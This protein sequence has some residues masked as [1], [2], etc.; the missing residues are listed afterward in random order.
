M[1]VRWSAASL[2]SG[3]QGLSQGIWRGRVLAMDVQMLPV[4]KLPTNLTHQS[5]QAKKINQVICKLIYLTKI[6]PKYSSF[7]IYNRLLSLRSLLPAEQRAVGPHDLQ[8]L[9]CN[10]Q[11]SV[12]SLP[13]ASKMACFTAPFRISLTPNILSC[14]LY[15]VPTL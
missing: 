8:C 10:P 14:L 15:G 3:E 5:N 9:S 7:T 12:R 1:N 4:I 6:E 2:Y 13:T 11:C